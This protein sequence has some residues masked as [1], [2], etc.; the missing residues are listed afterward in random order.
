M[1]N[2]CSA[3]V[4][5]GDIVGWL[6]ATPIVVLDWSDEELL[7]FSRCFEVKVVRPKKEISTSDSRSFFVVCEGSIAV[8]AILPTIQKNTD[9]IRE[10]LCK[11]EVG[12]LVYIPAVRKLISESNAR[13]FSVREKALY[14]AKREHKNI[15][16]MIDSI[17]I[18]SEM[19]AT[20]L[21]LGE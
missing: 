20:V 3:R 8:S 15:L 4:A 5:I 16:D 18:K 21:L 14:G 11:K 6:K 17:S 7:D 9:N 2:G 13:E 1:G 10:F 19:G 12:D